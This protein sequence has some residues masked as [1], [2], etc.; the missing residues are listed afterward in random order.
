M[1]RPA[2]PSD[3]RY[4]TSLCSWGTD[5]AIKRLDQLKGEVAEQERQVEALRKIVLGDAAAKSQTCS[6]NDHECHR[7]ERRG[8][9]RKVILGSAACVGR[10]A[11]PSDTRSRR[12]PCMSRR[13]G[14]P[15]TRK[16]R[17]A[18]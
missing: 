2:A 6:A 9:R 10:P 17:C 16:T 18:S 8:R 14:R 1:G 7:Q 5:E 4:H 11:A 13:T 3:T 15:R 12:V